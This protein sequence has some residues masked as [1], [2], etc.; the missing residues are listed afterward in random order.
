MNDLT[1]AEQA[2][3]DVLDHADDVYVGADLDALTRR[4]MTAVQAATVT[5]VDA[6]SHAA[7]T[8]LRR[9][10]AKARDALIA[11]KRYLTSYSGANAALHLAATVHYSPLHALVTTTITGAEAAIARYIPD[12]GAL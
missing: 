10:L 3:Y 2:V 11:C 9:E 5:P 1:P 8:D 7:V 6:E 4:I 12:G